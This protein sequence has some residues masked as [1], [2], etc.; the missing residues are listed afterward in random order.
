[1]ASLKY[2]MIY[3]HCWLTSIRSM[4]LFFGHHYLTSCMPI[5]V[6]ENNCQC[7]ANWKKTIHIK[8]CLTI[9]LLYPSYMNRWKCSSQASHYTFHCSSPGKKGYSISL[10]CI[11]FPKLEKE[12]ISCPK[13]QGVS[14]FFFYKYV[15][16]ELEIT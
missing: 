6:I 3:Q 5:T 13:G 16:I 1:M 14:F 12:I 7:Q 4:K 9:M 10:I 8:I 11:S 15:Q 2:Q